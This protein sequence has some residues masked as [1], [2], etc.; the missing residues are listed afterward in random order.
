MTTYTSEWFLKLKDNVV[1]GMNRIN[2]AFGN[3]FRQLR[4]MQ[5]GIDEFSTRTRRAGNSVDSLT[6]RLDRL[7]SR[8]NRINIDTS[9]FERL[10]R[11][12]TATQTRLNNATS[13]SGGGMFS[14]S[15][16][17]N[18]IA[19]SPLGG[20]GGLA[21]NPYVIGG[22]AIGAV[23]KFGY[24]SA[25]TRLGID[26]SFAKI[27]ATAQLSA[28]E[29]SK[30]RSE[31]LGM[32]MSGGGNITDA[33]NAFEK[34]L[35]AVYNP[36][37]K[38]QSIGYAKQIFQT[39][40]SASKAGFTDINTVADAIVGVGNSTN[41]ALNPNQV[42]NML[43]AAKRVGKGELGDFATYL[44]RSMALAPKGANPQEVAGMYSY[45]TTKGFDAQTSGMA[46]ENVFNQFQ[47]GDIRKGMKESLGIDMY[48]DG[49]LRPMVEIF[50]ELSGKLKGLTPEMQSLKLEAIGFRDMQAKMGI[51]KLTDDF[52]KLKETIFEVKNA[53]GE[54]D[55]ALTFTQNG[56]NDIQKLDNAW[57][58][59]KDNFG[60]LSAPPLLALV[61]KM[62]AI[63]GAQNKHNM[64]GEMTPEGRVAY[65]RKG[66]LSELANGGKGGEN[67]QE[68]IKQYGLQGMSYSEM[69]PKLNDLKSQANFNVNS[70]AP[71]S[72]RKAAF[73]YKYGLSENPFLN[74]TS[75]IGGGNKAIG[76]GAADV[77]Q[78]DAA[79]T[80]T[81]DNISGGGSVKSFV[82][83][84][85]KFQ[86][87]TVI[88]SQTLDEG[89]SDIEKKQYEM[90]LRVV[91][92]VELA[93][94]GN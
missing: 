8:R 75:T 19:S 87:Q 79:T 28:P 81:M 37:Q 41:G 70:V 69:L 2:A 39:S 61:E 25:K 82:V 18:A 10:N 17:R 46:L 72:K 33:P 20:L 66:A 11:M 38:N 55:S 26:Q 12:I 83:N 47:R 16:F 36:N 53:K 88:N 73:M 90:L 80:S 9:E 65:L 60:K 44:P 14:G 21:S 34:I 86:D 42:A 7:T 6:E 27:N 31:V 32:G 93:Q 50:G 24:D 49:Q 71:G 67:Y 58:V 30:L 56:L 94:G 22:A 15:N 84:I 92:G 29:L 62:N 52:Q 48:K 51:T 63:L 57:T 45:L 35:S 4:N 74:A 43:F 76:G 91:Q 23:G 54:L 13:R 77:M 59:F 5:T 64:L 78:P 89:I 1:P 85:G 3:S 40:L 68:L